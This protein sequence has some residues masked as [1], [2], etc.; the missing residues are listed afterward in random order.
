MGFIRRMGPN[1]HAAAPREPGPA[2]EAA[3]RSS[4]PRPAGGAESA[5]NKAA[6]Q[7]L[8]SRVPAR[9]RTLLAKLALTWLEC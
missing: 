7:R 3:V 9:E 6:G 1:G 4:S 5:W 2:D 8:P